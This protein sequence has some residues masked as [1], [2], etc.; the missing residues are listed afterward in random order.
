[1]NCVLARSD[2][3]FF[4]NQQFITFKLMIKHIVFYIF[5]FIFFSCAG[6][7][8]EDLFYNE[9]CYNISK[10]NKSDKNVEKYFKKFGQYKPKD[11]SYYYDIAIY[12][13]EKKNFSKAYEYMSI[14]INHGISFEQTRNFEIEDF[15]EKHK[16]LIQ[17][18]FIDNRN[19]TISYFYTKGTGDLNK[20]QFA[21]DLFTA[22]QTARYQLDFTGYDNKIARDYV[23]YVDSLNMDTLVKFIKKFGMINYSNTGGDALTN[24]LYLHLKRYNN[25]YLDSCLKDNCFKRLLHPSNYSL[26]IDQLHGPDSTLYGTF[27][28]TEKTIFI[29]IKNVDVLR[30]NIGLASLYELSLYQPFILP[31]EYVI[32]KDLVKKYSPFLEEIKTI[33]K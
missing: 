24:I 15:D 21:K 16:K 28:I 26:A 8:N 1:M 12:F 22:D 33:K 5:L 18:N 30:R 4:L 20:F 3:I 14:A 6:Q 11:Y 32:P 13:L 27:P 2:I 25:P 10:E 7:R 19:K 9:T 23:N 31:K 29:D 17:T